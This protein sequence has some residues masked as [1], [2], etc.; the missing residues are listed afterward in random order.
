MFLYKNLCIGMQSI[1]CQNRMF[2]VYKIDS[3]TSYRTLEY[4]LV[5]FILLRRTASKALQSVSGNKVA[6]VVGKLADAEALISLKDLLNR[7]GSENLATEQPFPKDGAG[8]DLRSNYLLNN[9]IAGIEE[10]DVVVLIGTNPRFEAPL[11]NTRLRKA[12]L[13][14]EQTIALIGPEVDLTYEYEV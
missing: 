14:R 13:H 1:R 12:Y 2:T 8:I 6:A 4:N 9:K 10:A 7:L 5:L 11:I 3:S